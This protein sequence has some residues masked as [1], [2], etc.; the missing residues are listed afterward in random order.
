MMKEMIYFKRETPLQE[1][2]LFLRPYEK[3]NSDFAHVLEHILTARV[4][5]DGFHILG[6][7]ATEDYIKIT[8]KDD[9]D[10]ELFKPAPY[11]YEFNQQEFNR[12]LS[13]IKQERALENK[14]IKNIMNKMRGLKQDAIVNQD[15]EYYNGLL[16]NTLDTF[17][18]IFI[19][20]D[21]CNEVAH[22]VFLK[23]EVIEKVTQPMTAKSGTLS[24]NK[25]EFFF[26]Y[27]NIPVHSIQEASTIFYIQKL[28]GF[29]NKKMANLRSEGI[30]YSIAFPMYSRKQI[31][32]FL[33]IS[34][35]EDV[36]RDF[37]LDIEKMLDAYDIHESID[38]NNGEQ[39]YT[40]K[41]NL[42]VIYLSPKF[43][44]NSIPPVNEEAIRI[45]QQMIQ[46]IIR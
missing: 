29:I 9:F 30:Y 8:L 13:E 38:I 36:K 23:D 17:S 24:H 6:A 44:M 39:A 33:L 45:T 42:S 20:N 19:N 1:I 43:L 25:V 12:A 2:S 34:F 16:Q 41:E 27:I 5:D 46:K 11:L 18:F 14:E 4:K 7:H 15:F 37:N 32:L 40:Y 21:I 22:H 35:T 10:I 26:K 3:M 28:I 31:E